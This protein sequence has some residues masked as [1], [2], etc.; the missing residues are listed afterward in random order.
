MEGII[1]GRLYGWPEF[2]DDG[3]EVWAVHMGDP[4]FFLRITHRPED[5]VPSGEIW[6][7]S[8]PLETDN[9]YALG[10]LM[11]F[12]PRSTDPGEVARLVAGAIDAIH[13]PDIMRRLSLDT[14][15]FEPTS[16]EILTED[17]PIG[18]IIGV[19][20]DPE[21]GMIDPA[22]WIAH[23]G[24]PPFTM[25]VCDLNEE[26]LEPE[27]VWASIG[28]GDVLA[29]LQWLSSLACEREDLRHHA[30]TIA[31][32]LREETPDQMPNLATV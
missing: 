6:D 26:D 24:L 2:A 4:P 29:H 13:N 1:V 32:L 7:L 10:N 31:E 8:F 5:Y 25:R 28:D 16:A 19:L 15:P 3:R 21:D 9:R 30:E 14:L 23:V 18:T 22:P 27:D 11:F 20:F 17:V 12:E